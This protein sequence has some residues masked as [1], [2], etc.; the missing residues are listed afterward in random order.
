MSICL[1]GKIAY[2]MAIQKRAQI[3]SK[4]PLKTKTASL[5]RYQQML[6]VEVCDENIA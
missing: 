4:N 1:E 6:D 3:F 2:R 5:D